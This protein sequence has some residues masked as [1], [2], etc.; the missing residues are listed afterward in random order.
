V[1]ETAAVKDIEASIALLSAY[2]AEAH[3]GNY[4]W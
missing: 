1:N 2:L 4:A 3:T